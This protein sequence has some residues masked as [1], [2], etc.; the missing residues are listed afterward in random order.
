[1]YW[2]SENKLNS[3]CACTYLNAST[4]FFEYN[5]YYILLLLVSISPPNIRIEIKI[6]YFLCA[7]F[8]RFFF[9]CLE[10]FL[11][12]LPLKIKPHEHRQYHY[13]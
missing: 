4:S 11:G 10:F 7:L 12:L 9:M 1:M 6:V 2:C 13:K 5:R 3:L 8:V